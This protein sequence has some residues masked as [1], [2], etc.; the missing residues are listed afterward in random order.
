MEVPERAE[1]AEE[2]V[3]AVG[4][5]GPV[6]AAGTTAEPAETAESPKDSA[7]RPRRRGRTTLM[8]ATAAL[9]GVVAGACTGY[10]IQAGR[11]PTK[12]PPLSQPV[13]ERAKGE[14]EPLSAARDRRVKTDGDLRKLLLPR[15]KGAR[16]TE[17]VV[18]DGWM[19]LAAYADRYENPGNAFDN[20]VDDEF[21]RAAATSWRVGD[22]NV[23]IYLVQFRQESKP[24]ASEW[25]ESG[26]YW[27]EH[28]GDSRSWPIPGTGD[29]TAFVHDK[30]ER[31][32][33]Y[34]PL[35][36]AEAYAWRGDVCMEIVIYDS[37]P[38]PKAKIMDLAERQVGRL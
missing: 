6:E 14:V 13:V 4:A 38:I 3:G 8:I 1:E 26:T 22:A 20:L 17:Y 18:A 2:E 15:P 9:L 12:L 33:G 24:A 29:G 21:R 34:L 35:Y 11:E 32:A 31:K 27:A 16:D 19:D 30:P 23:E 10:L 36:T 5:I 28:E 37:K 7:S 25:A